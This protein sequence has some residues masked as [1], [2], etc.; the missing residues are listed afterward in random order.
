MAVCQSVQPILHSIF[1]RMVIESMNMMACVIRAWRW[2]ASHCIACVTASTSMVR[3]EVVTLWAPLA[4]CTVLSF[5][6]TENPQLDRSLVIEPSM[7][8]TMSCDLLLASTSICTSTRRCV[9]RIS[10]SSLVVWLELNWTFFPVPYLLELCETA[11]MLDWLFCLAHPWLVYCQCTPHFFFDS[12]VE[13][14]LGILHHIEIRF[15]LPHLM[16]C[17]H[18][19]QVY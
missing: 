8:I 9:P 5:C 11:Y 16:S 10:E 19:W 12:I 15:D 2:E 18:G 6:L 4:P 7:K 13:W 14:I 3:L 17:F 1:C